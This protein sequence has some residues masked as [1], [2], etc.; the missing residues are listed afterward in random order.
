M[1]IILTPRRVGNFFERFSPFTHTILYRY[2]LINRCQPVPVDSRGR[3]YS[4]FTWNQQRTAL[5]VVRTPYIWSY[6]S[7]LPYRWDFGLGNRT[8]DM[9]PVFGH[10][11]KALAF[12]FWTYSFRWVSN[13][14]EPEK[15]LETIHWCWPGSNPGRLISSLTLYPL[16]HRAPSHSL[17]IKLVSGIA[18]HSQKSVWSWCAMCSHSLSS[19]AFLCVV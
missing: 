2:R 5:V 19:E 16:C 17:I 18:T 10:H 1:Y 14:R 11:T 6:V 13:H 4:R 3:S 9:L 15:H 12:S 7:I 8:R